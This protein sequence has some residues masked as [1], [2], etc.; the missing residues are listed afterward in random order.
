MFML[1]IF[2]LGCHSRSGHEAEEE[3]REF[4]LC[5]LPQGLSVKLG[6]NLEKGRRVLMCRGG[7]GK[8]ATGCVI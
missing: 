5:F 1:L 6:R 4:H 2:V 8:S 7:E 3:G